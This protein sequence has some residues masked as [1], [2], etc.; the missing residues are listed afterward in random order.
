MEIKKFVNENKKI[1]GLFGENEYNPKTME[2]H[3]NVKI[4][5]DYNV[6]LLYDIL[7]NS[8]YKKILMVAPTASGKTYVTNELMDKLNSNGIDSGIFC[9]NR[10][11]NE[12][13]SN[14][15]YKMQKVVAG[16]RLDET[17]FDERLKISSVYDKADEVLQE[18][19]R[20]F[21]HGGKSPILFVDEAH[22]II[23]QL[24]FRKKAINQL[25]ELI[26]DVTERCGGKIVFLTATPEK[27]LNLKF[28]LIINCTPNNYVPVAKK[29]TVLETGINCNFHKSVFEQIIKL[30]K[31]GK[32]PF[33]RLNDKCEI[34]RLKNELA[35]EGIISESVSSDDKTYDIIGNNIVYHN[36]IYDEVVNHSR[37]PRYTRDGK[38]IDVFFCT[39]VLEC[40]TN[41][42]M[43][44]DREEK[45]LSPLFCV[46]DAKNASPDG[47]EQFFNRVRYQVNDCYLLIAGTDYNKIVDNV[48][49]EI[50]KLQNTKISVNTD[51]SYFFTYAKTTTEFR[52]ICA[53][54]N[55]NNVFYMIKNSNNDNFD[56]RIDILKNN[57]LDMEQ[58][59]ETQIAK[60]R[61]N[62][63]IL[64]SIFSGMVALYDAD[65]AKKT[66]DEI[67]GQPTIA[68]ATNSLGIVKRNGEH[69]VID[70]N[71]LWKYA[72]DQYAKQYFFMKDL[73]YSELSKR[74]GITNVSIEKTESINI[75]MK[76]IK[77]KVKEQNLELIKK[78][79]E[80]NTELL[81]EILD[82]KNI[83]NL[84]SISKT[85]EYKSFIKFVKLNHNL[86][87]SYNIIRDFNKS[88]CDKA[89][90]EMLKNRMKTLKTMEKNYIEKLAKMDEPD[91]SVIKNEE[92]VDIIKIIVD[93]TY[94]DLFVDGVKAGISA[95][96]LIKKIVKDDSTKESVKIYIKR[97]T[98]VKLLK[99]VDFD[100]AKLGNTIAEK[101]IKIALDEFYEE[102][103]N[104]E[105]KEKAIRNEDLIKLQ[106]ALNTGLKSISSI[107]YT[108]KHAKDL[109][110]SVFNMRL[111][112][113]DEKKAKGKSKDKKKEDKNVVFVLRSVA[114]AA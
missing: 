86:N 45:Q 43:V 94:W 24:D 108:K 38:K 46:P 113:K 8:N 40:G 72:Y 33:V 89:Y 62:Y 64:N 4:G 15:H 110:L 88:G 2:I 56:F 112:E 29:L 5:S 52:K 87:A 71:A 1:V 107:Y 95:D 106:N 6:E 27:L 100:F 73:F 83:E 84:K 58:I 47:V 20:R 78:E 81:T 44:G 97:T 103:A 102:K 99:S 114:K 41:I 48:I 111:M 53:L 51:R 14:G 7:Q 82:D 91:Y 65:Y 9:P 21:R 77:E 49:A 36:Y 26:S 105:M 92:S 32:I 19:W 101:E 42:L 16:V 75:N 28:D 31:L 12:Q 109:L 93:S 69:L 61:E 79:I 10:V 30:V 90:A 23:E 67:L 17:E 3:Y 50:E 70:N 68:G 39:S 57:F 37:L 55:K 96:L 66:I 74:L 98:T 18:I 54:C 63:D 11:Q 25:N 34:D 60:N 13:N 35:V 76:E 59:A 80:N 104:G 85:D 22:T